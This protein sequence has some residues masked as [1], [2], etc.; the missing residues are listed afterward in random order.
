M[1]AGD[2]HETPPPLTGLVD[3][4]IDEIDEVLGD[5]VVHET[6]DML[7]SHTG[8]A[9]NEMELELGHRVLAG[10]IDATEAYRLL[11]E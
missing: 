7:E 4:I 5:H 10:E 3:Q 2:R 6:P 1:T 8:A 9:C 11:G